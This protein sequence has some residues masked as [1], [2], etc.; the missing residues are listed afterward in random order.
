M[1]IS[2]I[3]HDGRKNCYN[4]SSIQLFLHYPRIQICTSLQDF[5]M[6]EQIVT[7]VPPFNCFTIIQVSRYVHICNVSRWQN[8]LLQLFH[9]STIPPS[10]TYLD[11]YISAMFHDGRTNCYN[12]S[13]IQLFRHY[14]RIQICIYLQ[15]FMMVEQIVTMVP[16]FNCS[17]I[18]HISS[19]VHICNVS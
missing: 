17:T 13:T 4:C 3:F 7:I 10:S 2:A 19:F 14:P 5:M 9:H 15:Y 12:C 16:P 8:K 6:V 11:M 1:Y 18:I